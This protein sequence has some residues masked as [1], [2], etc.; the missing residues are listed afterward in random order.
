MTDL[1]TGG[2]QCAAVRYTARQTVKFRGYACHCT[3]CQSRTG[4]AFALQLWL[5][6]D[7]LKVE[8]DLIEGQFVK[9]D[10]NVVSIFACPHCLSHIYG[11]NSS[12]PQF[13][14][15]RAG[16]LDDSASF[17]PA[18][19]LWTRSKQPWIMIPEGALTLETQADSPEDWTGLLIGDGGLR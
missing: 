15:L 6:A 19:H 13:L 16:T 1:L 18:F 10:G 2:C 8:G 11:V 5:L 12:R 3:N 14:V 9:P 17:T 7:D 4:S